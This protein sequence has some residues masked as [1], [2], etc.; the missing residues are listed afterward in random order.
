[1]VFKSRNVPGT[2][3]RRSGKFTGPFTWNSHVKGPPLKKKN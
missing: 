3:L 1:M 2:F